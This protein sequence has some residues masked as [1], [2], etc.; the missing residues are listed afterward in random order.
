MK[1]A[2]IGPNAHLPI[3]NH[4]G[5]TPEKYLI[6]RGCE[7]TEDL[8]DADAIC[9]IE[10]PVDVLGFARV[11]KESRH[12]GLLVVQEPSIVR[13]RNS[14]ESTLREFSEVMKVGRSDN[15][16]PVLWP[17]LQAE[18]PTHFFNQKKLDK[19]CLVA[20]DNLSLIVGEL[21][22]LR[23]SVL[24]QDIGIDLYGRGWNGSP[25]SK[26]K[27]MV[28]ETWLAV[29]SGLPWTLQSLKGFFSKQQNYL[30]SLDNKQETVSLY[31]VS[32]VIEN[33]AGYVS[34]KLLEAVQ[35][36]SIPVYVGPDLAP[37][38]VP[39]GI[40]IQVEPNAESVLHG[41]ETALALPYESWSK[42]AQAWLSDIRCSGTWS[43]EAL[44]DEIFRRLSQISRKSRQ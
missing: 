8:G 30:G 5:H 36:G 26:A 23:R 2:L 32:V 17:I 9:S 3:H 16:A 1:I 38:G 35:A 7:I 12:K 18:N 42:Q 25:S 15:E 28:Y 20:S 31:K 27:K 34:E 6:E 13:P 10:V 11:P 43:P 19:A 21:Y 37:F 39:P 44:W 24:S 22:S 40:V 29:S 4:P 14:S 41:V 33:D